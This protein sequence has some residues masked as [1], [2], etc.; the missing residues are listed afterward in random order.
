MRGFWWSP[1]GSSLLVAR[2]KE[3][4]VPVWWISDPTHPDRRPTAVRYPAAGMA[5][6]EV[7]LHVV[8]LSGRRQEI[9]WD[10]NAFP[11]L[12]RVSWADGHPPLV[13]VQSRDQRCVQVLTVDTSDGSTCVV[14]EHRE[15]IWA[16]LF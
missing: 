7:T 6:A 10:R 9:V 3:T 1:V 14:V 2:V 5:N 13:Q 15:D 16:V 8:D 11:Y 4:D 12:A